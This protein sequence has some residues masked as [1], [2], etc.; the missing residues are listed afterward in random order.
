[1]AHENQRGSPAPPAITDKEK[2][3][4]ESGHSGL[5]NENRPRHRN[6]KKKERKEEQQAIKKKTSTTTIKRIQTNL[7]R[8]LIKAKNTY[9]KGKKPR[10]KKRNQ[11][12]QK[13]KTH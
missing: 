4:G 1:M 12:T 7:F 5:K 13:R 11:Q 10:E 2:K 9:P 3:K 8:K 6:A